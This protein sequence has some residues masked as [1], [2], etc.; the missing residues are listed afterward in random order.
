LVGN[1][2]R[3]NLAGARCLL[4]GNIRVLR[5]ASISG[6]MMKT[7]F[8]VQGFGEKTDLASGRTFDLNASYEVIKEAVE[9]TGLRCVRADEVVQ[10]GTIEGPMYEWLFNADLVIADLSTANLNAAFELGVR[11]GLKRRATVI[12]AEQGF[13]Y[14]F[15]VSHIVIRRYEH[16]GKDIGRREAA[17]FQAD[18]VAAIKAIGDS[19]HV[20]SPVYTFLP[21]LEP[22]VQFAAPRA[23]GTSGT[24]SEVPEENAKQLLEVAQAQMATD[25]F[26]G[27]KAVLETVRS[28]RPNDP[29]VVQRLALATYK[30][31]V[32]TPAQALDEA[33]KLLWTLDPETTN[34]PE[35]LGIWGAIHKRFWD[36]T[37]DPTK[38][39]ASVGAY[40]R[41]FYLKQ[42]YYNGINLAFLLNVRAKLHHEHGRAAEAI[43]DFVIA[44]R[45]RAEVTRL[46][47]KA[48]TIPALAPDDRFWIVATLWEAAA[49]LGDVAAGEKR[50]LELEALPHAGWMIDSA[51]SQ[52]G[53]LQTLIA[54]ADWVT[55]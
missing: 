3:L 12:V 54:A 7:C 14:P 38:L 31:K 8:V 4:W 16:L 50:R 53:R 48:L 17:R 27:A 28:M 13:K 42:D 5:R 37:G 43:A 29:Y 40:E 21:Q 11:Y 47:E 25:N 35:T 19:D 15:D 41:G 26:V 6:V 36:L 33:R 20:D 30:S 45:V 1:Q 51:R 44:R 24:A 49:G 46:C 52:I 32:P 34:D 22:P 10:S 23:F 39:D 55:I 2:R 9:S 18:L